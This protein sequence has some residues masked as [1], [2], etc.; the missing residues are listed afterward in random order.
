MECLKIVCLV[1]YLLIFIPFFFIVADIVF[2]SEAYIL[3]SM[4]GGVTLT[5]PLA[6][7]IQYLI[8]G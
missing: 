1:V 8:I 5:V 4:L 6:V 2:I 3:L 7:Y